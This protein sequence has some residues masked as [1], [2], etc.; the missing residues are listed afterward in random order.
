MPKLGLESPG[1]GLGSSG[2]GRSHE[3]GSDE[4][5]TETETETETKP[6]PQ[7]E[8]F[9][10]TDLKSIIDKYIYE[11]EDEEVNER[12][13]YD[14]EADSEDTPSESR[15]PFT[16]WEGSTES[17]KLEYRAWK[18]E[19]T[20]PSSGR[21]IHARSQVNVYIQLLLYGE[22]H[23]DFKFEGSETSPDRKP[24]LEDTSPNQ[25]PN[26]IHD[27]AIA[28]RLEERGRSN[29]FMI[30]VPNTRTVEYSFDGT[31]R[32]GSR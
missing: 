7:R 11:G 19:N 4:P 15:V 28:N 16:T 23:F 30:I 3:S 17:R 22:Q 13:D 32:K 21:G 9:S 2:P 24:T 8:T 5:E 27:A 12:K 6:E 10:L 25:K 14:N 31:W 18:T 26:I 1:R 29:I 20:G